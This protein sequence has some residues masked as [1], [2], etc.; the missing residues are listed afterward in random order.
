MIQSLSTPPNVIAAY[1]QPG[2][3]VH[4][5]NLVSLIWE[6]ALFK[7]QKR[8]IDLKYYTYCPVIKVDEMEELDYKVR[9]RTETQ[10]L[11]VKNLIFATNGYGELFF[12]R[13]CLLGVLLTQNSASHHQLPISCL[14]SQGKLSPL[15]LKPLQFNLIHPI[16]FQWDFLLMMDLNM[17]IKGVSAGLLLKKELH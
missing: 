9:V 16:R 3:T 12:S 14:N 11:K 2:A 4:P 6:A 13:F 1:E 7:A 17:V 8:G 15:E 10:E 5:L